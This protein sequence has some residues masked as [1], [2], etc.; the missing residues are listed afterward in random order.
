MLDPDRYLLF[1]EEKSR[2]DNEIKTLLPP[3]MPDD[4]LIRVL[5]DHEHAARLDPD[6]LSLPRTDE[7]RVAFLRAAS[8]FR[9]Y[10][11]TVGLS[12]ARV[13][14]NGGTGPRLWC[15]GEMSR[16]FAAVLPAAARV[17]MAVLRVSITSSVVAFPIAPE[18]IGPEMVWPFFVND[19]GARLFGFVGAETPLE[20]RLFTLYDTMQR[21]AAATDEE[22]QRGDWERTVRRALAD[23][24]EVMEY[25]DEEERPPSAR[26]TA[27]LWQGLQDETW[28]RPRLRAALND[29]LFCVLPDGKHDGAVAFHSVRLTPAP[30]VETLL[31]VVREGGGSTSIIALVDD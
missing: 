31:Q 29:A 13:L 16:R 2:Y 20:R 3:E 9:R 21:D 22:W 4:G 6:S 14:L 1:V 27:R 8:P 24:S 17:E 26:E 11:N 19:Y 12:S 15:V 23:R 25:S 28:F 18:G 5:V 30:I 7:Q 10:A